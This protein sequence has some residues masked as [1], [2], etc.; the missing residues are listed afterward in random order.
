MN[1]KSC[2]LKKSYSFFIAFLLVSF[3]IGNVSAAETGTNNPFLFLSKLLNQIVEGVAPLIELAL[4][5]SDST[6]FG[7]VNVS[8]SD[9]LFAKF[10]FTI[11][12][13][14]IIWLAL[15]RV[16]FFNEN[17][18]YLFFI[19]I[20]S[21]ILGVRFLATPEILTI[22]LPYQSIAIAL[23]AGVP[24]MIYFIVVEVGMKEQPAT[25][26]RIAW[27]FFAIV[28][29][30]LWISRYESAANDPEL[31][32]WLSV[33]P[34]TALA[35][36]IM[37]TIDGTLNR[38]FK[39]MTFERKLSNADYIEYANLM[40]ERIRVQ[41]ALTLARRTPGDEGKINSL[42]EELKGID[43]ALFDLRSKH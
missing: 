15:G 12:L 40:K 20:T 27:V 3:L 13:F 2:I 31:S 35:S 6:S 29:L 25:I 4:G 39:R 19:S 23:T 11:I 17:G 43:K 5:T 8:S 18:G 10:L 32:K 41:D 26:R 22:L 38:F 33:Y 30:L 34:L 14:S 36:I 1:E 24:F 42:K 28:F 7:G 16:H 9:I 21:S 37:V